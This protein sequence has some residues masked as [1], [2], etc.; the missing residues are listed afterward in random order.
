MVNVYLFISAVV[1]VLIGIIMNVKDLSDK[2]IRFLLFCLAGWGFWTLF[3]L[4]GY[5]VK[6]K[7]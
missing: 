5:V 4:A 3:T 2:F 6:V 7:P 1:F